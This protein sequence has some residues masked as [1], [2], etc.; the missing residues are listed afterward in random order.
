MDSKRMTFGFVL[1]VVLVMFVLLMGAVVDQGCECGC[2]GTVAAA[3]PALVIATID[4]Q[5]YW[6]RVAK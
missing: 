2:E 5:E 3:T 4:A 6:D 1:I